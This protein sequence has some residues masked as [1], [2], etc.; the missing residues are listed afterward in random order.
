MNKKHNKTRRKSIFKKWWFYLIILMIGILII[1]LF[2]YYLFFTDD[3]KIKIH[4][5]MTGYN[6]ACLAIKGNDI[7][8]TNSF[9][10][11]SSTLRT[12][13]SDN[14]HTIKSTIPM[15]V[16]YNDDIFIKSKAIESIYLEGCRK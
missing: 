16:C 4:E 2:L 10:L 3:G 14:I 1:G 7:C 5:Y 13:A 8:K 6:Y 11:D 12:I 9:I 15:I